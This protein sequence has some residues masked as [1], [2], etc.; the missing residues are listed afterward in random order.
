MHPAVVP[1]TAK[2]P[3]ELCTST[4]PM[5]SERDLQDDKVMPLSTGRDLRLVCDAFPRRAEVAHERIGD[6]RSSASPDDA[7]PL[8]LPERARDESPR[9]GEPVEVL[10]QL[11]HADE[12]RAGAAG[13]GAAPLGEE[14]EVHEGRR[15]R[16]AGSTP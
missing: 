16:A 9:G 14:L 4:L 2:G 15:T 12:Q 13:S 7:K 3:G 8:V 11:E 1:T 6:I 10:V 5:P